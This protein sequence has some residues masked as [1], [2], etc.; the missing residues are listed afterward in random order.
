MGLSVW[1][2]FSFAEKLEMISDKLTILDPKQ[3]FHVVQIL[4]GRQA[5]I[6][7]LSLEE[8]S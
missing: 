2:Q 7:Y 5:V 1:D 4:T 6:Q 8:Q 3:A